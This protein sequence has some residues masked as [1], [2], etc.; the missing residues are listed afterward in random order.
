LL[1]VARDQVALYES[2]QYAYSDREGIAVLFDRRQTDR[3]RDV[4]LVAGE[5]R[6]R[7]RRSLPSIADDLR[8]QQYV[9]ARPH[10]RRPHD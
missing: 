5:R 10:Y 6:R 3:R 7:D 2:L 4:Q 1:I 8:F 9:L